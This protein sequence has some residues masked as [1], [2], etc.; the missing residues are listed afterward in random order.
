MRAL[1]CRAAWVLPIDRAP[2]ADGAVLLGPDGRITAVGPDAEVPAP[3]GCGG[4]RVPLEC[5]LTRSGKHPYPPRAHRS[6]RTGRRTGFPSWIRRVIALK[7]ERSSADFLAA[8]K[9]GIRDG[10]SQELP[11]SPTLGTAAP[12]CRRCM[13]W[14]EAGSPTRKS[15]DLIRIRPQLNWLVLADRLEALTPLAGNRI[16]LGVSPHAP[17]SVSGALYAGVAQ[18]ARERGYPIAV[19]IAG[20]SRRVRSA[21]LGLWRVRRSVA[22]QGIPL[23]TLAWSDSAWPGSISMGSSVRRPCASTWCKR[24]PGTSYSLRDA[25]R[26]DSALSPLQCSPRSR[27]C[28]ASLD[29]RSRHQGRDRD[30]LRGQCRALRPPCRGDERRLPWR[31]CSPRRLSGSARWRAPAL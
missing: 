31:V 13:S 16:R 30:R 21:G 4:G 12:R 20:I 9:Q 6:R 10:W 26:C 5:S 27:G 17:Y 7:A 11:P 8:A 3:P 22:G 24:A 23:P 2:I 25:M 18:L 15:S 1:R 19:H 28:S 29:A 14:A